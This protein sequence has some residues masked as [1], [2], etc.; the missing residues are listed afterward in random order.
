MHSHSGDA[1]V[2][3][4][5]VAAPGARAP[6]QTE[7]RDCVPAAGGQVAGAAATAGGGGGFLL[8]TFVVF[9]F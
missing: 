7:E 9:F 4:G 3:D 5:T 6:E 2:E 8:A 1:N